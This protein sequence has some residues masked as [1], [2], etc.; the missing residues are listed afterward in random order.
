M[1]IFGA[2][3]LLS[4]S[5]ICLATS[6]EIVIS[7]T[8][9]SGGGLWVASAAARDSIKAKISETIERLLPAHVFQRRRRGRRHYEQGLFNAENRVE[10][11]GLAARCSKVATKGS[12]AGRLQQHTGIILVVGQG[13]SLGKVIAVVFVV[14]SR[15]GND[16]TARVP[17]RICPVGM[18][19]SVCIGWDRV[20][21]VVAKR[22]GHGITSIKPVAYVIDVTTI[23]GIRLDRCRIYVVYR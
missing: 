23:F 3:N 19:V 15:C 5:E 9:L 6:T 8:D 22:L 21:N 14:F 10:F 7:A 12:V 13:W 20:S 17:L 2:A 16:R 11:P 4:A 1:S 18:V